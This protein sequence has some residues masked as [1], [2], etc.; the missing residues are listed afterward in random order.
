[1]DL[2]FLFRIIG[3]AGLLFITAGVLTKNRAK[4]DILFII[5]GLL[6]EAYS[7]YLR[8]IIFIPLQ[9]IF[10]L[11]AA[12]DLRQQLTPHHWWEKIFK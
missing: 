4:Q 9:I 11:S 7:I 5:G 6:L 8:D 1:M 2:Q 10:I 3:A 12:Y